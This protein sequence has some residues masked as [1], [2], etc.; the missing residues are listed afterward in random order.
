MHGSLAACKP[1]TNKFIALNKNNNKKDNSRPGTVDPRCWI[2][3]AESR[4]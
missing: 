2:S 1:I 4:N 3:A